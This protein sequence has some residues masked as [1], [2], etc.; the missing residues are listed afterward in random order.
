MKSG[1]LKFSWN[2][3]AG[4]PSRA[5]KYANSLA[6][7]NF[8]ALRRRR[9]HFSSHMTCRDGFAFR[10]SKSILGRDVEAEKMLTEI[11]G[12]KTRFAS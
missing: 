12:E 10:P 6:D 5:E 9:G 7:A 1:I 2:I 8:N 11:S 3:D 4:G